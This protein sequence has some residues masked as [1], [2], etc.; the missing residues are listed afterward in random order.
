MAYFYFDF[1]DGK[2][3]RHESLIR[4]LIVQLS[5]QNEKYTE[6]LHALYSHSQSGKYQPSYDGLVGTLQSML[7]SYPKTYIILDALDECTDREELL[8][9]LQEVSNY[10]VGKERVQNS[11]YQ[12][13]RTGY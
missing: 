1:N 7:Q 8:T 9:F 6:A 11:G 3:Q 2:K 5:T 4:S 10:N 12:P 13:K